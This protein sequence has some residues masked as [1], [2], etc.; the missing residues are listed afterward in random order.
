V[1]SKRR[2]QA[3]VVVI[4][5]ALLTASESPKALAQSSRR[6][7]RLP[8]LQQQNALLQQQNAVLT[9]VQQT[10]AL[11]QS[12][13]QQNNVSPQG[14]V[15]NLL[16]FQQQQSALAIALQQ[17]N[18]LLQVSYRQNSA[19][20]ETALRQLN[21]L[22]TAQQQ[23]MNLQGALLAQ[24]GQLTPYQLQMLAQEQ[25]LL[26]QLLTSQPPPSSRSAARR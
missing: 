14:P 15:A 4:A 24:N 22:Q 1:C 8:L 19:L 12:V 2:T 5:M 13:S 17:T 26:T 16:A 20:S 3:F 18:A 23:T 21:T 6:N 9:A 25:N 7:R 10:N 11:V